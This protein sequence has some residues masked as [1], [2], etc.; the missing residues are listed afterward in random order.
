MRLIVEYDG[1]HHVEVKDSWLSDLRRR[2][3]LDDAAWRLLVVTS[4]GIY[5][6][7]AETVA[8]VH[9]ALRRQGWP[10]LPPR[11]SDAWRPHFPGRP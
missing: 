8:R 6:T 2:E 11:P 10:G 1:R 7:P 4:D 5:R 9:G 3:E